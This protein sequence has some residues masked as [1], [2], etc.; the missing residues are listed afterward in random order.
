MNRRFLSA[1]S[2]V[3]TA[4]VAAALA[5]TPLA[6]AHATSTHS[7][8]DFAFDVDGFCSFTVHLAIHNEGDSSVHQTAG[9]TVEVG[10]VVETD[11][12]SAN[13]KTLVGLPY[14][15]TVIG[16]SDAAGHPVDVHAQGEVWRFRLPDGRIWS[17][18]GGV[19]FLTDEHVGS[20]QPTDGLGP[21]CDALAG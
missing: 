14:H 16:V 4:G 1:R 13:G 15:Y 10:H 2:L 6:S 17:A 21:V 18:G 11:T 5:L 19:D 9:G 3:T 12:V 8:D 7:T 20:W